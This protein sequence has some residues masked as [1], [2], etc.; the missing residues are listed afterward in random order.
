MTLQ[1][2]IRPLLVVLVFFSSP[3]TV[4]AQGGTPE[5][6]PGGNVGCFSLDP[7]Y[8]ELESQNNPRGDCRSESKIDCAS[9]SSV[10]DFVA[11]CRADL[12]RCCDWGYRKCV[13]ECPSL[14]EF[15][16]DCII[17]CEENWSQAWPFGRCGLSAKRR[18]EKLKTDF[19]KVCEEKC[20]E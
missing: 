13:K 18:C 15:G 10:S 5:P 4:D 7:A 19:C 17:C 2:L 6:L 9:F 20:S 12:L 3:R 8:C 1:H 16:P 14:E 11:T